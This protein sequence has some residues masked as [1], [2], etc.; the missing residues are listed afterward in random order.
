MKTRQAT[1]KFLSQLATSYCTASQFVVHP[2]N[3]QV[4]NLAIQK[5]I[6]TSLD[7][8]SIELKSQARMCIVALYNC[9]PSQVRQRGRRRRW[10]HG[11]PLLTLFSFIADDYGFSKSSKT[12]P[13]HG[14][15]LHSTEHEKKYFRYGLESVL[16]IAD[17][18]F[19]L[20]C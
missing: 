19:H 9:N 3:Q 18:E 7:Q 12:V 8:K 13:R 4:V 17:L 11:E 10:S 20:E 1:L 15:N 2:Q 14:E 16:A 6:Q 5:I